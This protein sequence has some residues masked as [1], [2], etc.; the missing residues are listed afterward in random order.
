[1]DL[2]G[3]CIHLRCLKLINNKK[4]NEFSTELGNLHLCILLIL[5]HL[6]ITFLC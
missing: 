5:V 3:F 1:M 6:H 2:G 4:N